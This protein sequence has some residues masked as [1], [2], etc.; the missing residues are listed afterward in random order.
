MSILPAAVIVRCVAAATSASLVSSTRSANT[1]PALPSALF[2]SA[3]LPASRSQSETTAPE[4][5]IRSAIA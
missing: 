2:A 5:S 4:A 3:S 1:L